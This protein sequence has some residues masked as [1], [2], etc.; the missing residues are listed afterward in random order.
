MEHFGKP[1]QMWRY[2]LHERFGPAA[3]IP[4][5]RTRSKYLHVPIKIRGLDVTTV[6][7]RDRAYNI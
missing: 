3:F 5:Q 2:Q 7:P 4:V 6:L 1:V